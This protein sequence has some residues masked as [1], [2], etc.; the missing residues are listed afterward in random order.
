MTTVT[1]NPDQSLYV[2]NL[3]DAFTCLGFTYAYDRAAAVAQ[4]CGCEPP[5]PTA[6]GT[7]DGYADY[8]RVTTAGAEH[9]RQNGTRCP[10]DLTP[11]LIG[12]EH[13]RVEVTDRYGHTRRF[14]VGKSTGWCPCHLEVHNTRSSGGPAVTGAPFTSVRIVR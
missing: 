10:V 3:G 11:Q 14:W 4:W 6:I 2:I 13:R 8:Q 5:D 12:L 1:I 7:K 9:A